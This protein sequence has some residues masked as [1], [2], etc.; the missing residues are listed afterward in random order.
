MPMPWPTLHNH[1]Q[2]IYI[3]LLPVFMT[4][5]P[6]CST[7][8][9]SIEVNTATIAAHQQRT[10]TQLHLTDT[11]DI[12]IPTDSDTVTTW[13]PRYRFVKRV[14]ATTNTHNSDSSRTVSSQH[15]TTVKNNTIEPIQTKVSN[16]MEILY[17]LIV[18]LVCCSLLTYLTRKS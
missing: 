5:F 1:T 4:V 12:Y 13:I 16:F 8:Q 6:S 3:L 17:M 7:K 11:I 18:G 10:T 9:K 15:K 2:L 14:G